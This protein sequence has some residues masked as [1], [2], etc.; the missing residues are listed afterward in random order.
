[1]RMIRGF[2]DKKEERDQKVTNTKYLLTSCYTH[3]HFC[4]FKLRFPM[5]NRGIFWGFFQDM[6]NSNNAY[7]LSLKEYLN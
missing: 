1:M 7:Q 5:Y 6:F 2:L 3:I 4:Q